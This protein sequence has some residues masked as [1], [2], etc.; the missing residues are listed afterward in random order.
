M[1]TVPLQNNTHLFC[2]STDANGRMRLGIAILL[3]TIVFT[4]DFIQINQIMK[5]TCLLNNI[6][7]QNMILNTA[8]IYCRDAV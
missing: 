1:L 5:S 4:N 6:S 7:L 3:I 8:V 2:K